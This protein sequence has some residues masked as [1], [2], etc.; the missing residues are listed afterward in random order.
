MSKTKTDTAPEKNTDAPPQKTNVLGLAFAALML[1]SA[2]AVAI[3]VLFV[4]V[5]PRVKSSVV[6]DASAFTTSVFDRGSQDANAQQLETRIANLEAQM[7]AMEKA[8]GAIS[9]ARIDG[10]TA[11]IEA[12]RNAQT[13]ASAEGVEDRVKTLEAALA[14]LNLIMP[15]VEM[16]RA[17]VIELEDLT[18]GPAKG[19]ALILAFDSLQQV[20]R[21]SDPFVNELATL[22]RL[23]PDLQLS[24]LS[25]IAHT[26]APSHQEL[27]SEFPALANRAFE[28]SRQPGQDANLL[29]KTSFMLSRIVSVRRTGPAAGDG[30]DAV[31]ARAEHRL[32]EHDLKAALSEL[33][34]LSGAAAEIVRPW[35]QDAKTR[36]TLDR[37]V[38]SL[39]GDVVALT[40]GETL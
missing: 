3:A 33:D 6:A 20:S 40:A 28:L 1:L 11:A 22:K 15:E 23:A 31:L 8:G 36:L 24:V 25:D 27:T 14:A 18:T 4:F 35:V 5:A 21:R 17:R 37:A 12:T 2:V 26:G 29:Q 32:A 9:L 34:T 10:L 19:P 39:K 7:N 38:S 30:V 16:L 13:A